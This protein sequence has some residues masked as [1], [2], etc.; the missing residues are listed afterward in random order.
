M[1]PITVLLL[2]NLIFL[3]LTTILMIVCKKTIK[4]DSTKDIVLKITAILVVVIHYSSLYV[5]FFSNKGEAMI[6][7]NMILPVFPCNIIMWLLVAVAFIKNKDSFIFKT[8]ADFTFIGGTLCGLI[9]V[10]F[11]INFLNN[12][13]LADYD[14]LKGLISHWVMIF[15]TVYI[16]AFKYIKLKVVE[17][18]RS[19]F[20]GLILFAICGTLVNGL[21][22]IFDVPSVNAMFMLEAP[23]KSLPFFNFF[24]IG[25]LGLIL[26]FIGL[27]IYEFSTLPK[28]ERWLF[29]CLHKRRS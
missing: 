10:F 24:T 6:E 18:T 29:N 11:N 17:S 23:L 4:K 25:L 12:P 8:L 27:N 15:G 21:F 7:N 2:F 20:L 9:G 3:A 5:D 1:K 28:E 16:F 14:I 26:A 22:A 13:N 19:I